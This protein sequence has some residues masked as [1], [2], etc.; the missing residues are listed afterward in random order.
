M[1]LIDEVR[2]N[3]VGNTSTSTSTGGTTGNES[4]SS[5]SLSAE[6]NR[7]IQAEKEGLED[8]VAAVEVRDGSPNNTY[9]FSIMISS[10]NHDFITFEYQCIDHHHQ[11][12]FQEMMIII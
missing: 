4:G 10:I 11:R 2:R 1:K 5:E 8:D 12:R 9:F 3:G 6:L 7:H